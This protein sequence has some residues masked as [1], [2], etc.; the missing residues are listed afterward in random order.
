MQFTSKKIVLLFVLMMI[1]MSAFAQHSPGLMFLK[2]LVVPGYG[3]LSQ[4]NSVGYAFIVSEVLLWSSMFY[5]QEESDISE[6]HAYEYAMKYAG[7]Q[8]GNFDG[9]YQQDLSKYDSWGY[10]AGGY[11]EAVRRTAINRYPDDP[12]AR[13]T[14]IEEHAYTENEKWNWDSRERRSQYSS[15]YKDI[16]RNKDYAQAMVGAIVLN[17]L[18]SGF[19]SMIS[20]RK[21]N[22]RLEMGVHMENDMTPVLTASFKF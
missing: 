15:Y 20:A 12:E 22:R 3:E 8:P 16:Q 21:A 6:R 19:N 11:N 7:I 9:K 13:T 4:G 10:E 1:F 14:Y 5:F 17:H 2:S 18:V